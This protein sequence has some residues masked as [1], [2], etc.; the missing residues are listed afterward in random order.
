MRSHRAFLA[1]WVLCGLVFT[2]AAAAAGDEQR[3]PAYLYQWT[4]DRGVVHITDKLNNVPPRYRSRARALEG[5]PA[6]AGASGQHAPAP[7]PY[8]PEEQ[9]DRAL[10]AEED[11]KAEWQE[12]LWSA[13]VRLRNAE[14][15]YRA[16]ERER[17]AL[18]EQ[19]GGGTSV[20]TLP[21][22]EQM[23]SGTA[24]APQEVLNRISVLE[25]E[26][27]QVRRRIDDERN[28]VEVVI[29]DEARKA[30]IP[31]GWLREVE[32]KGMVPER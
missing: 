2:A 4:D 14:D 15:Q 28:Q 1:F 32:E 17:D 13:R 7:E 16:L 20:I 22:G 27:V 9:R 25:V 3:E 11:R 29:P 12:R 6:A 8:L 5:R 26:M 31:P 18:K 23:V 30:G 19:Y 21:T 10:Q 24:A